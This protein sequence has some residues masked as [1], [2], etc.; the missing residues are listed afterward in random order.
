MGRSVLGRSRL[1]SASHVIRSMLI[2]G[3]ADAAHGLV[4]PRLKEVV[5]GFRLPDNQDPPSSPP[6]GRSM[7]DLLDNLHHFTCPTLPHLL[8]LLTHQ[9][10]SFP[11]EKT[12]LIIVDSISI[13]FSTA[14]PRAVD[15]FDSKQVSAKKNDVVQWAASRRWS[16]IGDLISKLGKL[17]ATRHLTVLLTSQTTTRVRAD[18]GAVLHPS[19]SGNFWDGGIS[20]RIVLYRDWPTLQDVDVSSQTKRV[21]GRRFAGVLKASGISYSGLG[22]VVPFTI[23]TVTDP[24]GWVLR[25]G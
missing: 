25:C 6:L 22:K 10:P 8:A 12:S 13:L 23:E 9:S 3:Y 2:A 7:E 4:G 17:A 21:H 19:I 18:T 14:F 11:P 16:V 20:S 5:G 15:S 24:A 1:Q